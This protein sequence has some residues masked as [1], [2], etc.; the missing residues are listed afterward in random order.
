[1]S[2]MTVEF[3]DN[4]KWKIIAGATVQHVQANRYHVT[5]TGIPL[6]VR[7]N[8][9]DGTTLRVSGLES[10]QVL[11]TRRHED[12]RVLDVMVRSG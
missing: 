10:T 12:V 3:S 1:M 2:D 7:I 4:G 6:W 8:A 9:L 11:G 5:L